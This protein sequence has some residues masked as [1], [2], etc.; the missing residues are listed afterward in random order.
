MA[1]CSGAA[2]HRRRLCDL[3]VS[4]SLWRAIWRGR[5]RF[6]ARFGGEGEAEDFA[7]M[8]LGGGVQKQCAAD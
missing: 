6:R 3:K 8:E 4:T 2:A 7:R 5:K 1:G